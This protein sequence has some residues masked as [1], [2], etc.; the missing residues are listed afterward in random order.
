MQKGI[1]L[2]CFLT[3]LLVA[4]SPVNA[5][6][7]NEGETCC[8]VQG[9]SCNLLSDY[10]YCTLALG[11]KVVPCGPENAQ[12]HI[13]AYCCTCTG[14]PDQCSTGY[15]SIYSKDM[16]LVVDPGGCAAYDPNTKQSSCG[17]SF[18]KHSQHR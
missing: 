10:T 1:F 16:S 17:A 8:P 14:N 3:N 15:Y 4:F 5:Q 2:T 6:I 13:G 11:N 7:C 9:S 18:K 12:S